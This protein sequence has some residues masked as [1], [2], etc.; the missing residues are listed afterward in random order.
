MGMFDFITG[1]KSAPKDVPRQPR[2][3]LR[4]QLLGLN[5]PGRPWGVRD[6]A[7]DGVDLI[8]EWKIVDAQ[9]YQIFAKAGLQSV[10][11]ILMKFDDEAGEIRAVDQEWT[12]AW[13]A[14]VP[15]LS[16]AAEAFRGQKKEISFGK[17][18]AFRE[19]DLQL[20]VV[21]EYSFKTSEIKDPLQETA[22]A[23]GWGWKGVAFGKL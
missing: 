6:G 14:G 12:V 10:F 21:Y 4:G 11:R 15:R 5:R 9:W 18:V 13:E 3:V 19:E 7:R 2:E 17:A 22:L 23:N 20:G 8:A 1:S 16:M